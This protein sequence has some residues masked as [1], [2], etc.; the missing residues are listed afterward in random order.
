MRVDPIRREPYHMKTLAE[1]VL[2]TTV[3]I[4]GELVG[5]S[6]VVNRRWSE[7]RPDLGY[8]LV[9]NRHIV[10]ESKTGGVTVTV[11]GDNGSRNSHRF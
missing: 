1:D 2:F 9:T 5:T 11:V 6:F 7:E 4:E 8:F 10:G 3:P